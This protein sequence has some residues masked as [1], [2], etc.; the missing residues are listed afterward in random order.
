MDRKNLKRKRKATE[1]DVERKFAV[2][3]DDELA[4]RVLPK[5]SEFDVEIEELEGIEVRYKDTGKDRVP[6]LKVRYTW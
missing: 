4:W 3:E 2:T 6:I 5:D 1:T